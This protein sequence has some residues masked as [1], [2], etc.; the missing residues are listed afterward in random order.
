MRNPAYGR[1]SISR[2]MPQDQK[3]PASRTKFTKL[4]F[5]LYEQKVSNLRP[6]LSITFS[7]GIR[8]SKIFGHQTL[9]SGDKKTFKW[10][11][12]IKNICKKKKMFSPR[13]FYTL[14][15]YFFLS[16]TNSYHSQKQIFLRCDFTLLFHFFPLLIKVPVMWK[17]HQGAHTA[18]KRYPYVP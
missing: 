12:Q 13:R 3:N 18:I 15:E 16:E 7:Q 1:Q 5:T 11:E 10:S 9:E 14:Y 6:L 8:K 17:R 2:P 4:F